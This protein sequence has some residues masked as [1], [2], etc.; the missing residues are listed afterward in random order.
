M[1]RNRILPGLF[2]ALVL[3][4]P[5]VARAGEVEWRSWNAGLAEAASTNRPVL[6]DVYTEWCG[7]CK[8]MDRDVYSR[9]D[10]RE[11]LATHFVTIKLDAEA[12]TP[13]KYEGRSLTSSGIA[14]RFRVSGYPTTVFLRANGEHLVNVPGYITADRFMLMLAYI[15]ED[16]ISRGEKWSDFEKNATPAPH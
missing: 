8:R 14:Q 2:A 3:V 7:W 9:A 6:V 15:G 4:A 13:A 10:V 5:A 11:Y 12:S 16:H 1:I